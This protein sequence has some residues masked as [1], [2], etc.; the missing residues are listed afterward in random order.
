MSV[1]LDVGIAEWSSHCGHGVSN[2]NVAWVSITQGHCVGELA[3]WS[4]RVGNDDGTVNG[5]GALGGVQVLPRP[6]DTINLA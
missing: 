2:G 1:R 4:G 3:L 6:P 5:V